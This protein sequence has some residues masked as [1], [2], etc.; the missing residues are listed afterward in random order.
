MAALYA[1]WDRLSQPLDNAISAGLSHLG[2]DMVTKDPLTSS[3]PLIN[4]VRRT[5][6]AWRCVGLTGSL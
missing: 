6:P 1:S 4:K 2:F 5:M 3:W